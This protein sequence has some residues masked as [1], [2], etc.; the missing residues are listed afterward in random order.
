M[1]LSLNT[2]RPGKVTEI[3]ADAAE[4]FLGRTARSAESV[5]IQQ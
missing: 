2:A 1:V 3:H 5:K 4:S